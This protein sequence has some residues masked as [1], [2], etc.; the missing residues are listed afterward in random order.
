[1][2]GCFGLDGAREVGSQSGERRR[3]S[4]SVTGCW[5]SSAG[6]AKGEPAALGRPMAAASVSSEVIEGG[7]G[8]GG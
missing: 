5:S 1:M 6:Q 4:V 2:A 3:G 7:S 8:P